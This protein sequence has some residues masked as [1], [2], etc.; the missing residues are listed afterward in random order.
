MNASKKNLSGIFK[1]VFIGKYG[2]ISNERRLIRV[3]K[4]NLSMKSNFIWKKESL[5]RFVEIL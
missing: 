5:L 2:C 1:I 4:K 3:I